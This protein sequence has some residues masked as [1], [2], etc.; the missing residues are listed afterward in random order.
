ME[1]EKIQQ[2]SQIANQYGSHLEEDIPWSLGDAFK[3]VRPVVYIDQTSS[4]VVAGIGIEICEDFISHHGDRSVLQ[5]RSDADLQKFIRDLD[6]ARITAELLNKKLGLVE[7]L[8][9]L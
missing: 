3:K 7:G 9:K 8:A 2:V 4:G 5:I 1:K 6:H